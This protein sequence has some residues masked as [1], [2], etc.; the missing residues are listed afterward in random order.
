M[1]DEIEKAHEDVFNVMLQIMDDGVLTDS[2][3]RKVDFKNTIIVMT[4][5][6]GARNITDRQK[7]LGFAGADEGNGVKSVEEIRE[8]VMK[9]LKNTF[10]P[11][12]L[13]RI[14]DII[15][16]SQLTREDIRQI[17][18]HMI[19][20]VAERLK[21]LGIGLTVMDEALDKLAEE[22]FDPVYGARP[23]RRKI[24]SA[25]EDQVAEKMLDGTLKDGDTARATLENDKI[26]V[27]KP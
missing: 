12:F 21:G 19:A 10:R 9:D 4:S 17:A 2:Q 8:L 27:D 1:F 14:D 5:N 22:G 7:K 6:I 11:E 23:L 20:T 15:V 18:S 24:Q 25:L 13:N 16:F 3:G 26:V